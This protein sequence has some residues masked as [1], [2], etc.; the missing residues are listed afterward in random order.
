MRSC[1]VSLG[2]F[3]VAAMIS[4]AVAQAGSQ[5]VIRDDF[6]FEV[7]LPDTCRTV[8]E[9]ARVSFICTPD[10]AEVAAADR[11]KTFTLDVFVEPAPA[12]GEWL[13]LDGIVA[14]TRKVVTRHNLCEAAD[15]AAAKIHAPFEGSG[16]FKGSIWSLITGTIICRPDKPDFI[17]FRQI[18][19]K[20]FRYWLTV[21][22]PP[23]IEAE[24]RRIADPMFF[25]T[26]TPLKD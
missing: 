11:D 8:P 9:Q 18:S 13:T 25:L 16:S 1:K 10:P 26:F 21:R 20:R 7:E 19:T 2:T 14:E 4:A 6:R 17:I 23:A 12:N 15:P 5:K 3:A 22:A 24:A